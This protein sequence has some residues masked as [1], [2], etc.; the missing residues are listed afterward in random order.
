MNIAWATDIHLDFV[1]RWDAGKFC[2]RIRQANAQALLLGGDIG[3]SHNL[4]SWLRFLARRLDCPVYFVL[5]NHDFYGSDIASVH[6]EVIALQT[7]SLQWLPAQSVIELTPATAL[8]GHDGWADARLGDFMRSPVV[9]NDYLHIA[10]L[11]AA[12]ARGKSALQQK[13]MDLGDQAAKALQPHLEKAL[14]Q[15]AHVVVL[16]HIPPFR[17]AC[18]HE[19]MISDDNWLPGF[20][21]HA[22]GEMLREVIKDHQDRNV[23][24]LCGHTHGEGIAH[25]LRNCVVHTGRAE[26]GA[27]DFVML[28]VIDARVHYI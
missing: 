28:E 10:D 26:Y 21:C 2:Q 9:L 4:A 17:D 3:E 19:G 27:P 18:W 14:K 7:D 23:T 15:F 8:I 1:S 13:L 22:M 5:G 12:R 25:P 20:T 16:T 24:V 11:V 6:R